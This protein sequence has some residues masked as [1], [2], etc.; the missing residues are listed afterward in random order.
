VKVQQLS[1]PVGVADELNSQAVLPCANEQNKKGY[2]AVKRV[3]DILLSLLALMVLWPFLLVVALIIV[4]DS[5]GASPIFVQTR[6][7]KDGRL[8]RFYKFR[9]MIPN[10]EDNLSK[11][12]Q[13]NEMDGPVF[14]IKQDPRIT[15]VGRIL[16]KSS[17]DE[18]PQLLNVLRGDMS[19][20][21]PRPA[22]VREVEQY[23]AYQWQRLSV[24]PGLTCLWQTQP[25][26]N[27]MSFDE[28]LELDIEYI[29]KRSYWVDWKIIF[30]T[31]GAVLSGQG[32]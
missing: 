4:I 16:R 18:L 11:L 1:R 25:N 7:G 21:G 17:I 10:A 27:D 22:I 19:L 6:V 5:P 29:R 23:N 8:F 9:T 2:L 15:K 32:V 26:R 31:F 28:W 20:V 30:D 14:K 12:L 24:I 13:Y 3:Q